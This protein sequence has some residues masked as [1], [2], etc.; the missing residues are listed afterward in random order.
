MRE[1]P[2]LDETYRLFEEARKHQPVELPD[3][4]TVCRVCQ[5]SG[6]GYWPCLVSRLVD[7]IDANVEM[8]PV[9]AE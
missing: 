4:D 1:A 6:G 8:G 7:W 3:G 5:R 9:T 2:T